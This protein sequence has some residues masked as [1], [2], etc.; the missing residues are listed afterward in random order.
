MEPQLTV[1]LYSKYSALSKSLMDMI[2]TSG[3]DFTNQFGLQSLCIDN[4]KIRKRIIANK[5]IQVTS[6]PCLLV[7]F[8]DGGIEKYDGGHAFEWVEGILRKFAPPQPTQPP[9]ISEEETWRLQQDKEQQ[10]ILDK[11]RDDVIKSEKVREENKKNYERQYEEGFDVDNKPK[12]PPKK[13]RRQI[14]RDQSLSPEREQ[15]PVATTSI[16]DLPSDEDD[17]V[18]SDRHRSRKPVGR[19]R[20]DE[21]NYEDG[22]DLFK[23]EQTNMRRP[24]KSAVKGKS[25]EGTDAKSRKSLDLMTKAKEMAKGREEAPA[26]P[27]HPARQMS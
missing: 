18:S 1:L 19:I 25:H 16:D 17:D 4:E 27:G 10:Q 6:V 7:I 3:V 12:N 8:P 14:K 2:Q 13:S 15:I 9:K 20:T 22:E 26:P 24:I 5:H 23:G 11:K 21:G